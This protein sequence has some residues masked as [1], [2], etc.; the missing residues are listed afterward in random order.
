MHRRYAL[1]TRLAN[2]CAQVLSGIQDSPGRDWNE[3]PL[4]RQV[5]SGSR[6]NAVQLTTVCKRRVIHRPSGR[7]LHHHHVDHRPDTGRKSRDGVC[8]AQTTDLEYLVTSE[9]GVQVRTAGLTCPP[10]GRQNSTSD[11]PAFGAA[12]GQIEMVIGVQRIGDARWRRG[13][14]GLQ[15]SGGT[16]SLPNIPAVVGTGLK[17]VDFLLL[18]LA[19]IVYQKSGCRNV[20]VRNQPE[21]IP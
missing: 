3:S 9:V 14:A 20:V 7:F 10:G 1:C 19:D 13:V 8:G 2:R 12:V 4:S 15:N 16:Q 6:A 17:F 11:S 5:D 21:W 18:V